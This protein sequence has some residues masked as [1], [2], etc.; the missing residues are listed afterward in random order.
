M[1]HPV[2]ICSIMPY[3]PSRLS[4]TGDAE[5]MLIGRF[6]YPDVWMYG[7][8]EQHIYFTDRLRS[9][10]ANNF[11]QAITQF[12]SSFDIGEWIVENGKNTRRTLSFLQELTKNDSK[13]VTGY[14]VLASINWSN[15]SV[16][17]TI[18]LIENNS[19]A[20]VKTEIVD[21]MIEYIRFSDDTEV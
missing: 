8:D 20:E 21:S 6:N 3:E 13:K 17:Y 2:N 16:Y 5:N 4:S 18:I 12:G 7:I 14:L 9:E 10:D 11:H 19:G 15:G 1:S